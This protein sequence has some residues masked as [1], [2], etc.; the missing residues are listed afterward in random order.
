MD[1]KFYDKVKILGKCVVGGPSQP[2]LA[3]NLWQCATPSGAKLNNVNLNF[4]P[5]TDVRINWGD[6]SVES[7]TPNTNYNHT[8]N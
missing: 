7:I 8:F 6:G 1:V 3:Y 4:E 5:S 2:A